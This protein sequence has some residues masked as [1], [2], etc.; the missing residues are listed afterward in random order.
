M[1][2]L[3]LTAEHIL[4]L[5][6]AKSGTAAAKVLLKQG[7]KV[8]V[9]DL[10]VTDKS[11][12]DEL[13]SLGA[14]VITGS[15]PV[16]VLDQIDLIVKNPGIPYDHPLLVRAE[17][18]EIP[19]ITEVEIAYL[20]T[21]SPIVA[22]TGSNG[23]TTTTTLI[24]KMLTYNEHRV[25]VAGNIGTVAIEVAEH[26]NSTEPLVLELSSFQL[27]GT[28]NFQPQ[29]A[30]LLNVYEAH[31]DYHHT[32]SHYQGAKGKIFKNQTKENFSVYNADEPTTVKLAQQSVGTKIPFSVLG[33]ERSGAWAD[34]SAVYFRDEKIVNRSEIALVGDHN[35][36]NILASICVAKLY[37]TPNT[38][39]QD[40]L[41]TFHGV[42]HR[43]QYVMTKN[44]RKFYNDS[45]ATNILATQMALNAFDSP[46]I[47][48]AG[49]LDRGN[50]FTDLTPYLANVK[51]LIAYGETA[52]KLKALGK[53]AK[54]PFVQTTD[55]LVQATKIAYEHSRADDVILLSP[56]CASWDQ[57][58]TFEERGDMFM[59][60]V[61]NL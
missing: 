39:I 30:V 9:N 34:R 61:H 15:H 40:V 28:I 29:V 57:F 50:E 5:G 18:Q 45:K 35:L 59:E 7:K 6:L 1:K 21:D 51:G 47:L 8:R 20:L 41:R 42:E 26:T 43:L 49:G 38:H 46:I 14:E 25:K 33:K 27:L 37:D 16:S 52:K 3:Q 22:V 48:I 55:D 53:Q 32:F 54:I 12:I 56:A 13:I 60:T 2:N 10:N 36:E 24:G 17:Q 44:R 31:L 58:R 19:I 4:V 23:K 11:L